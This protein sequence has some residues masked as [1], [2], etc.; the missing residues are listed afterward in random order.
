MV[1]EVRRNNVSR[2]EIIDL[3]AFSPTSGRHGWKIFPPNYR[4]TPARFTEGRV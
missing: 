3:I 4:H 1:A 2:S